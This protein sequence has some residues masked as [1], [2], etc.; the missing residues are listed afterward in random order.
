MMKL[1]KDLAGEIRKGRSKIGDFKAK[2]WANNTYL[3]SH[4]YSHPSVM[5]P[6]MAVHL[7]DT[8]VVRVFGDKIQLF[9]GG[10]KT[11]TT[12]ERINRVLFQSELDY[13]VCQEKSLWYVQRARNDRHLRYPFAEGITIHEDGHITG[14]APASASKKNEKLLKKIKKYAEGYVVALKAGKIPLPSGGDCWGCYMADKNGKPAFG[15]DHFIEHLEEGY[16]VPSL[17]MNAFKDRGCGS[18]YFQLATEAMRGKP[19]D[20]ERFGGLLYETAERSIRRFLKKGLG[21]PS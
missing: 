3:V 7:H 9:T 1:Y 17:L 8:D 18:L 6:F 15:N 10:W 21:L 13:Y 16:F 19:P 12:K 11:V 4:P 2:K 20:K 5:D 14:A